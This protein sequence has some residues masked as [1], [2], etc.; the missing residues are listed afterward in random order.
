MPPACHG[1]MESMVRK[2]LANTCV[3]GLMMV[4]AS[5]CVRVVGPSP[6]DASVPVALAVER[7]SLESTPLDGGPTLLL[8]Y[9]GGLLTVEGRGFDPA[10]VSVRLQNQ[11]LQR[12]TRDAGAAP[13]ALDGGPVAVV[14]ALP[15][16]KLEG[17]VELVQDNRRATSVQH[18]AVLGPGHPPRAEFVGNTDP[19]FTIFR[20]GAR[21]LSC[22]AEFGCPEEL[23]MP[24]ALAL[25]F[26]VTS[27]VL[28]APEFHVAVL[29]LFGATEQLGTVGGMDLSSRVTALWPYINRFDRRGT[30]QTGVVLHRYATYADQT[31]ASEVRNVSFA[32]RD[33]GIL[34]GAAPFVLPV[35]TAV[36]LTAYSLPDGRLGLLAGVLPLPVVLNPPVA[37]GATHPGTYSPAAQQ[38]EVVWLE[39]DAQPDTHQVTIRHVAWANR[40]GGFPVRGETHQVPRTR[41]DGG[42]C[43]LLAPAQQPACVALAQGDAQALV[44][45]VG[46]VDGGCCDLMDNLALCIRDESVGGCRDLTLAAAA[47]Y[48]TPACLDALSNY[49]QGDQ[50][51]CLANVACARS[52]TCANTPRC[53]AAL[54]CGDDPGCAAALTQSP[55]SCQE[56]RGCAGNATC[57]DHALCD[58]QGCAGTNTC[59]KAMCQADSVGQ[60]LPLSTTEL[61]H[62][63]VPSPDEFFASPQPACAVNL[64][65]GVPRL[66]ADDVRSAAVVVGFGTNPRLMTI[67]GISRTLALFELDSFDLTLAPAR[68]R[69]GQL[70]STGVAELVFGIPEE[71]PRLDLLNGDGVLVSSLHVLGIPASAYALPAQDGRILSFHSNHMVLADNAGNVLAMRFF[72]QNT[73]T[74]EPPA[75]AGAPPAAVW[76]VVPEEDRAQLRLVQVV[77]NLDAPQPAGQELG[78][79]LPRGLLSQQDVSTLAAVVAFHQDTLYV[80]QCAD[81]TCE[82][83]TLG[84]V[85]VL[86]GDETLTVQPVDIPPSFL[87][88]LDG[89]FNVGLAQRYEGE[90]TLSNALLV[91]LDNDQESD[92]VVRNAQQG[93]VVSLVAA[94]PA[95]GGGFVVI[96]AVY[97]PP[98]VNVRAVVGWISPGANGVM[99]ILAPADTLSSSVTV[100]PD[101]QRVYVGRFE[102]ITELSIARDVTMT[103]PRT[104]VVGTRA[105]DVDGRPNTMAMDSEGTRLVFTDWEKQ[106]VGLLE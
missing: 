71:G 4:W 44:R 17:Q 103:P 7:L 76:A 1:W 45:C 74:P 60:L 105:I 75:V 48:T 85:A 24:G 92:L 16:V 53:A 15:L 3:V 77:L 46:D 79:P 64:D 34:S 66:L 80:T 6:A 9:G 82:A 54:A 63:P 106:T 61:L 41:A 35:S 65:T 13:A 39:C 36:G 37:V 50:T 94:T 84:R 29:G 14:V 19:Q 59:L 90:G 21:G 51:A 73:F 30:P 87:V 5:A 42:A 2:T 91:N 12:V 102:R 40:D 47:C 43:E 96:A 89:T 78:A 99:D 68:T 69:Y 57:R 88:A 8:G 23:T 52:A 38:P 67:L 97:E 101:G 81:P 83:P 11:Q 20:A 28:L 55:P 100:S 98:F 56:V 72:P 10:L 26:G 33:G 49:F 31:A 25:A 18:V 58:Q 86:T 22:P 32:S 70:V 27:G 93:T 95:P 62:A 104:F